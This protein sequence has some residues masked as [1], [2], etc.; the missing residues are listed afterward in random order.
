M[1]SLNVTYFHDM[2]GFLRGHQSVWCVVGDLEAK[3]HWNSSSSGEQFDNAFL[4]REELV[5]EAGSAVIL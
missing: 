5:T 3:V 4:E 1:L 2:E